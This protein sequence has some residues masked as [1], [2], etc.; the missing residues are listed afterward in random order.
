MDVIGSLRLPGNF[1]GGG[2]SPEPLKPLPQREDPS[3]IESREKLR[4]SEKRRKGR[5]ATIL[6]GGR[7]I[8]DD[9][10][11]N[12]GTGGQGGGAQVLGN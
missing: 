3:V 5:R 2:D 11:G 10:L 6:T 8:Q 7:G 4:L 12:M 9:D 1:G